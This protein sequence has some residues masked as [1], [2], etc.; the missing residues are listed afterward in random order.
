MRQTEKVTG[1]VLPGGLAVLLATAAIAASP[2]TSDPWNVVPVFP[3]G[4]YSDKDDFAA[5]LGAAKEANARALERQEK[6]NDDLSN[7][8]KAL[9]PAEMQTRM[10]TFMMEN[11]EEATKLMQQNQAVGEQYADAQL[12]SEANRQKLMAELNE[13]QAGWHA[14]LEKARAP[15]DAKFKELDGRAQ[16][17]LVVVGESWTYAPWAVKEYDA[18]VVQWNSET[19]KT[20]GKWW[21]ASGPFQQWLK[22]YKEHLINDEIPTR[23]AA[24]N[25]GAGFMVHL[26]DTPESSFKSTATLNAVKDYIDRVSEVF[27]TRE[28]GPMRS[29]SGGP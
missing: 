12:K 13:L 10:Q 27:A 24:D 6:A 19:E 21:L 11:P 20:C 25:V 28:R 7:R 2:T 3:S 5:K 26:L 1:R 9:G 14:A 23:E 29:Y 15:I 17:A 16:K 4:C 18:L 22:R 8:V